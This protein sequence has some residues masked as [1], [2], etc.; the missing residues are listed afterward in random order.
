MNAE[1]YKKDQVKRKKAAN[2][3]WFLNRHPAFLF[4]C[5]MEFLGNN[6]ISMI[7]CCKRGRSNSSV[8]I[9]RGE[10]GWKKFE[11]QFKEEDEEYQEKTEYIYVDYKDAFDEKW[12]F[13]HVKYFYD[14]DLFVFEG[15]PDHR[16]QQYDYNFFQRYH[17]FDGS[18]VTFEDAIIQCANKTKK[19]FGN[20]S[21]DDNF[22][23]E[24]E[25]ENHKKYD[26]FLLE[27]CLIDG[28]LPSLD[29]NYID[30]TDTA[31]NIRWA[32]WFSKTELYKK[33][34]PSFNKSVLKRKW[35]GN[36]IP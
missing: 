5:S 22:F 25:K 8:T 17:G 27:P 31:K 32:Q 14:I 18:A 19:M 15:D 9:Y 2:A 7:E 13:D 4:P 35:D 23:T 24:K 28:T 16:L 34:Y 29:P 6:P 3:L 11:K 20:F 30:V 36:V 26:I 12:E 1:E 10:R 21:I 33:D